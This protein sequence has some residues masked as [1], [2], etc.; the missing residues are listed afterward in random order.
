MGG[1]VLV[2][3]EAPDARFPISVE[4]VI[5]LLEDKQIP[6]DG[7]GLLQHLRQEDIED[8]S[9]ANSFAKGLACVQFVWLG[10]QCSARAA[11]HLP[12]TLLELVTVAEAIVTIGTYIMW[13]NKPFDVTSTTELHISSASTLASSICHPVKFR[14]NHYHLW[15][16]IGPVDA[17]V[18]RI[19]NGFRIASDPEDWIQGQENTNESHSIIASHSSPVISN[20]GRPSQEGVSEN[21]DV[22]DVLLLDQRA[23]MT[24]A[25][26]QHQPQSME[27]HDIDRSTIPLQ[28]L[29]MFG[30]STA[31]EKSIPALT[32]EE[33]MDT[34]AHPS[35]PP[36][37]NLFRRREA[38]SV[39]GTP[40]QDQN[41][42]TESQS[43]RGTP[44]EPVSF[45]HGL[46]QDWK[47]TFEVTAPF[48]EA[49]FLA[50]GFGALHTAAWNFNFP[51]LVERNLWRI[52]S[53]ILATSLPIYFL[54]WIFIMA[55][56][57][58]DS[59][60]KPAILRWIAILIGGVY[61]LARI[62]TLAE[63]L[64]SLRRQP[65]RVYETTKWTLY[66]PHF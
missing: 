58:K 9:K 33:Q 46:L 52:S 40:N 54:C 64:V 16:P 12:F 29:S 39:S 36:V 2:D 56:E 4:E 21:P 11:Q 57:E 24:P 13:W 25:N 18:H 5:Q 55:S 60:Q 37:S 10:L 35:T 8:R 65:L 1:F 43:S 32:K 51:T 17:S 42:G 47:G 45:R 19:R 38:S 50:V 14:Y 22:L 23:M 41:I 59:P 53:L 28:T 26:R 62:Y 44:S 27:E 31:V 66:F 3:K 61:I 20:D 30:T 63:C 7:V 49:G 15:G 48:F 6:P 34:E